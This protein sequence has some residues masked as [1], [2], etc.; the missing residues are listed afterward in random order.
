M[1][2]TS[3]EVLS[4]VPIEAMESSP[5]IELVRE[6]AMPA[7]NESPAVFGCSKRLLR[8]AE[9]ERAAHSGPGWFDSSWDLIRGCEVWPG[10]ARLRGGIES[11]LRGAS[12][13]ASL[14]AS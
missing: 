9:G 7:S 11:W 8:Q 1:L 2:S 12:D 13:S 4:L 3:P 5:S 6:R 10:D 14:C